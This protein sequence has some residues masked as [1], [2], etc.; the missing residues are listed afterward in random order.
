MRYIETA[1]KIIYLVGSV[2]FIY[3][4]NVLSPFFWV[5]TV[6][7]A[8]LGAILIFNKDSSYR[9]AQKPRDIIMRRI[10]GVILIVFA[11]S[12]VFIL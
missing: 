3:T 12:T 1:L 5:Y 10:E 4:E 2:Y 7:S 11:V 6:L 9:F 8:V